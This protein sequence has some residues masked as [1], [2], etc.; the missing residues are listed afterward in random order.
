[1]ALK[2]AKQTGTLSLQGRELKAFPKELCNF[3]NL[4]GIVDNWWEA[5]DLG[6]IDLS[7][8]EIPSI[9]E[10]FAEQKFI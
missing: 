3:Q 5:F 9:P 10:E 2:R 1:M 7:N 4:E 6:K 8:N